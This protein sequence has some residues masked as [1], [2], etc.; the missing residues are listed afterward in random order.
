MVRSRLL[1][2]LLVVTVVACSPES[3]PEPAGDALWFEGAQLIVGD[4]SGPIENAAFLVE[5]D[6]FTWVGRAGERDAPAG[7]AR[8]DLTGKTVIPALIDG[9]NHIGLTAFE[10]ERTAKRTTRAT[11][12]WTSCSVMRTT[13]SAPL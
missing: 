3:P 12:S 4:G 8:V 2:A 6:S 10:T 11:T 1:A 9:H 13:E 7:A 5:G